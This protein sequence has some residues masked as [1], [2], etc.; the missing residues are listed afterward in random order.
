MDELNIGE[1]NELPAIKVG[2]LAIDKK[3][4]KKRLGFLCSK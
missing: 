3:I 2:R 1:N 4:F